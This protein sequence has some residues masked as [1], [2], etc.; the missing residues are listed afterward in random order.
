[1]KK[2]QNRKARKS[3][4][5]LRADF[6][7]LQI[8]DV[9]KPQYNPLRAISN[10]NSGIP[11]AKSGPTKIATSLILVLGIAIILGGFGIEGFEF[12]FWLYTTIAFVA[13]SLRAFALLPSQRQ[14]PPYQQVSEVEIAPIYSIL[15]AL[16]KE[17]AVI[18]NLTH[19]LSLMNW[20]QNRLDIIYLC[21]SDDIATQNAVLKFANKENSRLVI[22]PNGIPKTKP[23]ALNFGLNLA[24]GRFLTIYDAE[25]KP[26][27][28]QLRE[29]FECFS[30]S[31][32]TIGMI[33]APLITDN[34]KESFI[35]A[36]FALDYAIW[37]RV[38]LPFF[39]RFFGFIP[40]GGT[41]NHFRTS[42]LRKAGG[43]DAYNLT[44]DA[45]LGIRLGRL[46]YCAKTI[47]SPT[48]EE[49]PPKTSQ[50]LRQRTRWIQGHLQ[51]IATHF[52]RPSNRYGR[53][54]P[55]NFIG[56]LFTIFAGPL[57][58]FLRIP[59]LII[60]ASEKQGLEIIEFLIVYGF[61]FEFLTT[62]IAI[63]RDGRYYLW[64]CIYSLPIYWFLQTIAYLRACVRVFTH[65]FVWE[66][67]AHGNAARGQ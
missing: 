49:S 43:W 22:V 37:F 39:A 33:Q 48:F 28:D 56:A 32:E 8:I 4:R 3:H 31:D 12:V 15:I 19:N 66:K 64:R 40:L 51:T 13:T 24:T 54:K 25:D 57:F 21:E 41:S 34:E 65:P 59:I 23:R 60:C 27:P 55:F 30:N 45:D 2:A 50:W 67:T 6:D 29:A 58:I 10:G 17:D 62:W 63:A 26:H 5:L 11:S 61:A 38:L 35:A 7:A 52:F 53:L 20:P 47:N 36:H 44:E 9:R 14:N 46:G 1:M 16:Y 18:E 42:V